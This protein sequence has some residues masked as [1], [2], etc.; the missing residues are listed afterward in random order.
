MPG[1]N[2]LVHIEVAGLSVS[3]LCRLKI[4]FG[5]VSGEMQ[6]ACTLNMV[7][8]YQNKH[9]IHDMEFLAGCRRLQRFVFLLSRR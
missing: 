5:A 4:R 2:H 8:L 3:L 6:I 1:H 9:K 7:F